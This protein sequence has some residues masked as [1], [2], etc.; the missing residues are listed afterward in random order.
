METPSLKMTWDKYFLLI[1]QAV[2]QRSECLDKKVG[3]VI[4]DERNRILATGYNGMPPGQECPC[5][6][7]GTCLKDNPIEENFKCPM[8][9]A[10]LN[11]LL[12][13]DVSRAH[14]LYCSLDPCDNC[15]SHIH[16][17]GIKRVV[18]SNDSEFPMRM[19]GIMKY[20]APPATIPRDITLREMF[21]RIRSYHGK[22]GYPKQS[23]HPEKRKKQVSE[24]GLALHQEVAEFID[25]F[26]WK[27]WKDGMW[28]RANTVEEMIDIFFF[29]GSFLELFQITPAELE[30]AFDA[31]L[32][33]NYNRIQN[34]YNKEM[35]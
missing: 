10:E 5:V 12:Q 14:T 34:G 23:N 15:M 3:C 30:H 6:L 7:A 27:P 16:A 17:A 29:L 2:A 21:N 4:V 20:I 8:V 9:H 35:K 25:S 24:L 26:D 32:K 28:D 33:E 1:T 31:K 11:A 13:C 19:Q 22:L 18:A